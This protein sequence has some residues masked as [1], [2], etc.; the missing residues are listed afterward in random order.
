MCTSRHHLPPR[1]VECLFRSFNFNGTE[2]SDTKSIP[3]PAYFI[4]Q[5]MGLA[6]FFLLVVIFMLVQYYPVW[7]CNCGCFKKEGRDYD[8]IERENWMVQEASAQTWEKM[9]GSN[10]Q[11]VSEIIKENKLLEN[12]LNPDFSK[13]VSD[14]QQKVTEIFRSKLKDLPMINMPFHSGDNGC[15]GSSDETVKADPISPI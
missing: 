3:I 2:I 5:M 10:K 12:I 9:E 13:L 6:G 1:Y 7:R 8:E 15:D 4:S 14:V 11:A